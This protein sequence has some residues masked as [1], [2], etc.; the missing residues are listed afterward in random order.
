MKF[1]RFMV[2]IL[3]ATMLFCGRSYA[4]GAPTSLANFTPAN[5]LTGSEFFWG[6]QPGNT[7][8]PTGPDVKIYLS[9][10]QTYFQP[11]STALLGTANSW[12]QLQTFAAGVAV[13]YKT[14]NSSTTLSIGLGAACGNVSGGAITLTLPPGTGTAIPN[15]YPLPIKDCARDAGT[16]NLTV[17]ANTGQTI[18]GAASITISTNGG[19]IDPLWNALTNN[20]DL[21]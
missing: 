15:G 1:S 4:Q 2:A 7:T 14:Y 10:L 11:L 20:W 12:S 21:F 16:N 17:A 13:N 9:Q 19:A 3:M 18:E 6:E 5:A 8:L